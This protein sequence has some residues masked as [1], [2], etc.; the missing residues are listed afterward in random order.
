V[1]AEPVAELRLDAT[2]AVRVLATDDGHRAEPVTLTHGRW[3]QARV[4]DGA[5]L[6]V[7]H[8]LRNRTTVEEGFR[9]TPGTWVAGDGRSEHAIDVDQTNDS[10]VVGGAV[11]V[12]WV[13]ADLDGPH[14][15]ADRLRRLAEAGFAEMPA[16]VGL[17]EWRNPD[18]DLVPVAVVTEHVPDAEDGWT[19]V[20]SEARRALGVEDGPV[21]AFADELGELVGRMHRAL[22]DGSTIDAGLASAQADDARATLDLAVRLTGVTDPASH[23]LLVDHRRELE[24]DLARLDTLTGSPAVHV[25]GD[26][27][28]GQVLRT[29]SGALRII[30]FDGNPTRPAPLRAAPGPAARD[31][32]GML[33]SLENV[34]HLV[35]RHT[36]AVTEE[37]AYAWADRVQQE[38]LAGYRRGLGDAADLFD[39]TLVPAFDREQVCREFV[40]AARHLPRWGYAP[41]AALRRR[42]GSWAGEEP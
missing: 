19:W 40:Y 6:A 27:H 31:V 4:G 28:V 20:A 16:L 13:A 1:P 22:A 3:Q 18:G 10:W 33:V 38:L 34:A 11:V 42:T 12:K 7:L 24:D 14:P 21:S 23:A 8:R 35:R 30:D 29:P 5:G 32:A 2:H 17:V 9:V 15:A 39:P 26:L 36:P 25:H 41:A 37:A